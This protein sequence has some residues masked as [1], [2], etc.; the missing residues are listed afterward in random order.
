M[1]DWLKNFNDHYANAI[2]ALTPIVLG[3]VS[4]TYYKV[5]KERQLKEG[6]AASMVKPKFFSFG[7]KFKILA[8]HQF[9]KL[10]NTPGY[11]HLGQNVRPD[12]WGKLINIK[13]SFLNLFHEIS[14]KNKDDILTVVISRDGKEK[15]KTMD[16]NK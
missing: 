13:S 6:D 8:V 7:R 2:Q 15:W 3:F 14:L 10:T 16:F 4:F 12:E 5:Y 11:R 9:E 1:I